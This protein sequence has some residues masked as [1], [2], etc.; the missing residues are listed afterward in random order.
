MTKTAMSWILCSCSII[1]AI[2]IDLDVVAII[3]TH[4]TII[5]KPMKAKESAC[6]DQAT[7]RDSAILNKRR[8]SH[9]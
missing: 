6:G 1:N 9:G 7:S 4:A 2:V 5:L 3:I 8:D